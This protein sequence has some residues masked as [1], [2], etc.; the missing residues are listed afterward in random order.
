MINSKVIQNC[1]VPFPAI[2]GMSFSPLIKKVEIKNLYQKWQ[3]ES[4]HD[5]KQKHD[6]NP[7]TLRIGLP[8]V[9]EDLKHDSIYFILSYL[10]YNPVTKDIENR[11]IVTYRNTSKV[12]IGQSPDEYKFKQYKLFVDDNVVAKDFIFVD[13]E[14]SIRQTIMHLVSKVQKLQDE[15]FYLKSQTKNETIYK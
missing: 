1:T 4:I 11:E 13:D 3:G 14:M 8:K 7:Y 10:S 5:I 9:D 6:E 2:Q 12:I 15:V